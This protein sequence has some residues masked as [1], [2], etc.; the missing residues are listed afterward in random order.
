MLPSTFTALD[1][2]FFDVH[3]GEGL[4]QEIVRSRALGY[5]GKCAIH[6]TQ[7]GP[8]NAVLTPSPESVAEARAI[9]ADKAKGV[10]S[11]R[12]N[13][14]LGNRVHAR[15]VLSVTDAQQAARQRR[16]GETSP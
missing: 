5:S 13:G 1:A 7:I 12:P 14:R 2:P 8:I 15:R 4:K 16:R 9:L 11:S 6:P 10:V 3:D